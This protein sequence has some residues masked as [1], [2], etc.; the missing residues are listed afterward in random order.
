MGKNSSNH[1]NEGLTEV[2]LGCQWLR[3]Q[4][5]LVDMP[6]LSV[7]TGNMKLNRITS[8]DFMSHG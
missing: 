5:L 4:Q 1:A 3:T 7:H 8:F 6:P 2:L